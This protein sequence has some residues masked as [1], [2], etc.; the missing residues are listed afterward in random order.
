MNTLG[1]TLPQEM[2][3]V[4]ELLKCYTDIGPA[5]IFGAR[6]IA[7]SLQAADRAVTSGDVVAMIQALQDL[8]GFT[9]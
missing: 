4:R 3:R 7:Q 6:M 9:E 2:A 1:D 5:G 8:R